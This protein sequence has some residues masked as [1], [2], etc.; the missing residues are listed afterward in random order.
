MTEKK[1]ADSCAH[2]TNTVGK[3]QNHRDNRNG[4]KAFVQYSI[5]ALNHQQV[6]NIVCLSIQYYR[7]PG[8]WRKYRKI[9]RK[10]KLKKKAFQNYHI[11]VGTLTFQWRSGSQQN[12]IFILVQIVRVFFDF[13][14]RIHFDFAVNGAVDNGRALQVYARRVFDTMILLPIRQVPRFESA[15][16]AT[17]LLVDALDHAVASLKT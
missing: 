15:D 6:S 2:I 5:L 13:Q 3:Y 14:N 4:R 9:Q 7:K 1:I 11:L 8:W 10:R 16:A 17:A 12:E